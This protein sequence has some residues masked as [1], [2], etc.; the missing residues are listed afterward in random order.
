VLLARVYVLPR[1]RTEHRENVNGYVPR[2]LEPRLVPLAPVIF[3]PDHPPFLLIALEDKFPIDNDA[4]QIEFC[5]VDAILLDPLGRV[6]PIITIR[7]MR[8]VDSVL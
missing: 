5:F 2:S 4:R 7:C 1:A 3:K 6:L 8:V